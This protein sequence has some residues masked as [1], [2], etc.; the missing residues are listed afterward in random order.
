MK[1]NGDGARSG[2]TLR[3]AIVCALVL[4]SMISTPGVVG[5]DGHLA[6]AITSSSA[7][8]VKPN[9]GC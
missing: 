7:A 2:A 4:S 3:E 1:K 6:D 8:Q 5:A 9:I